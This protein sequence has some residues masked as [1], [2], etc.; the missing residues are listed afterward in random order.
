M[1]R[2]RNLSSIIPWWVCALSVCCMAASAPAGIK[3]VCGKNLHLTPAAATRENWG[4]PSTW[5]AVAQGDTLV[6]QRR[7]QCGDECR[8]QERIVL[9]SIGSRCPTLVSATITQADAGSPVT[10]PHVQTATRGKLQFQDWKP[11]GGVVSGRLDAEF[12]LEFY[13]QTQAPEKSGTSK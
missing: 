9:A 7:S 4:G 5:S 10:T 3:V 1:A 11:R 12:S 2:I 13:V 6:L 8:Y